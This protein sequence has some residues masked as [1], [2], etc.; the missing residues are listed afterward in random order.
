MISARRGAKESAPLRPL[1]GGSGLGT[2]PLL[3]WQR[4]IE[5]IRQLPPST[6]LR[7]LFFYRVARLVRRDSTFLLRG[8]FYEAPPHA[9]K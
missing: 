7:R 8:H 1:P 9:N 4:D 2:T 6:D 5:H 3:R